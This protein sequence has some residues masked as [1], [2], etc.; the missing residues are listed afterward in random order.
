MAWADDFKMTWK[1][2]DINAG[3]KKICDSFR[4]A[5]DGME[6]MKNMME[7]ENE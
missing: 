2:E 7:G 3:V 5:K 1:K 6:A 4:D